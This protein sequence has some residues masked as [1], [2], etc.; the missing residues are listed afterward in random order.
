MAPF[1]INIRPV[2][3][4]DDLAALWLDLERRADPGFFLSWFWVGS[5]LRALPGGL[6]TRLLTVR[7]DATVVGLGVFVFGQRGRPPR[8]PATARREP[9]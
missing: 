2:G 9:S 5:W 6:D 1:E 7:R 8:G 4:H 3:E